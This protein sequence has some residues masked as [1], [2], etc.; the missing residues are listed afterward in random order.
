MTAANGPSKEKAIQRLEKRLEMIPH[1]ETM[2]SGSSEFE[3]W[4]R[5]TSVA[6]IYTFGEGSRQDREFA[7]VHYSPPFAF[8]GMPDSLI[9]GTYLGG[10][11]SARTTLK[12]MIDEIEEY[13]EDENQG[14]SHLVKQTSP[15]R[16]QFSQEIFI[17]H[18]R[19]D[20]TKNSIARFLENLELVPVILSEI[21][22]RGLTIIE[23]FER[24]SDV[25]FAVALLTPDD[26]GSLRGEDESNPRARQN[27]IFELGFFIGKLG[28]GKVCALI[29][30]EPEIP[31]DYAGVEYIPID[32]AGGWKMRL[33]GELKAAGFDVDA[34]RVFNA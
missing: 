6:I 17:V 32:E 7:D 21:P 19:D 16:S 13:W 33:V 26:T 4:H 28:R 20:G 25:E 9:E 34:N 11:D 22:A 8:D 1:L 2:R 18:G 3:K 29:K 23:K 14:P 5:D 27:V 31:S 10:L 12:S 15:Q 24:H 30:G